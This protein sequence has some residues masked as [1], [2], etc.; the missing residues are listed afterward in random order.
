MFVSFRHLPRNPVYKEQN[1]LSDKL[2]DTI[3]KLAVFSDALSIVKQTLYFFH[4]SG[5][6]LTRRSG[7]FRNCVQF[8]FSCYPRTFF[9]LS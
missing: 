2:H 1:C 5:P 6:F 7:N 8:H 3:K 4:F 9:Q